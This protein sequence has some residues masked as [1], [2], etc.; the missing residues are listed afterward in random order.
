MK[1]SV[2]ASRAAEPPSLLKGLLN[3]DRHEQHEWFLENWTIAFYF[4]VAYVVFIYIGQEFMKNRKPMDLKKPII[5]WNTLLAIF[6]IAACIQILPEFYQI[7]QGENG[8][9]KSV[10]A[11]W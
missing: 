3:F 9:H 4:V 8:F 11:S 1:G 7:L 10:C 6:S 2:N 5:L